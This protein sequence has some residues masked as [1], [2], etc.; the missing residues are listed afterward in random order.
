[1]T[2]DSAGSVRRLTPEDAEACAALRR[3]MLTGAPAAFL[4]HPDE[5]ATVDPGPMRARLASGEGDATFGAFAP[6]AADAALALVGSVRLERDPFRKARH[7][8]HVKGLFVAPAHRGRGLGRRLLDAAVAHARS[9]AGVTQVDLAVS[10][11]APE[12]RRLYEA[13]GFRAWGTERRA[14]RDDER[15]LDRTYLVRFLDAE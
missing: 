2:R 11:A 15:W 14:F 5:D 3:A 7:R 13:A 1:M 10:S 8:A 4:R 12:A 9:L 6:V